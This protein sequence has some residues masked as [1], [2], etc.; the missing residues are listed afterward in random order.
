MSVRRP[1]H[2]RSFFSCCCIGDEEDEAVALPLI[3]LDKASIVSMIRNSSQL[4]KEQAELLSSAL[5]AT[6]AERRGEMQKALYNTVKKSARLANTFFSWFF[7]VSL[8]TKAL[9]FQQ[10]GFNKYRAGY[11]E[12]RARALSKMR[13]FQVYAGTLFC[14]IQQSVFLTREQKVFFSNHRQLFEKEMACTL[15]ERHVD[16]HMLIEAFTALPEPE[17]I[18][19]LFTVEELQNLFPDLSGESVAAR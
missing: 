8:H 9:H 18:S 4:T 1:T 16:S 6:T 17:K 19:Y 13:Q 11:E 5:E 2:R 3:R 10:D 14:F 7:L 15:D 12:E